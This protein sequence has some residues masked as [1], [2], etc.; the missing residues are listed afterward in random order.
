MKVSVFDT[1]VGLSDGS[2][3]HFDIL[4]PESQKDFEQ[5]LSYGRQFLEQAGLQFGQMSSEECQYCHIEAAS[6]EIEADISAKGYSIIELGR[7]P[8]RLPSAPSRRDLLLH[9]RAHH[10]SLRFQPI[11]HLSTEQLQ[12]LI[13]GPN[14]QS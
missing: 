2:C 14:I 4:I 11:Q 6:P 3:L 7:I 1:Y 10:P 9:L 13:H 8:A 12:Q 5:I